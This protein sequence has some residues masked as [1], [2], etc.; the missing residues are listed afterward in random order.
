[1]VDDPPPSGPKGKLSQENVDDAYIDFLAGMARNLKPVTV[2]ADASNGMAGKYLSKL[3]DKLNVKLEGIY[4]EPDGTFPNHEADPLKPENLKD[5]IRLV[6][7]IGASIGFCFDG[8]ADRVA[9]VDEAGVPIGCDLITAIIAQYML[10][11]HPG[12]P[13][14]YDLRSSKV[15]KDVIEAAG[16]QAVRVRVGHAHVKRIM[17]EIGAVCG[18][19]LSGHYYFQLEDG[20]RHHLIALG[21][22]EQGLQVVGIPARLGP[23]GR[24]AVD[25]QHRH[26]LAHF[27]HGTA[28][29]VALQAG[30]FIF[31][32]GRDLVEAQLIKRDL[33]SLRRAPRG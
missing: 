5:L 10:P 23:V 13:A 29:V 24:V 30:L 12:K 20:P 1:M 2:A 18:G 4:L 32:V 31:Q 15:V 3:C 22:R 21:S 19:E 33:E 17:R 8:D 26:L 28:D 16:G 7:N 6:P 14:T 9:I 25:D 11:N 27:D